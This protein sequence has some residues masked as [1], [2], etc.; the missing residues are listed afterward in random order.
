[1]L[2]E[3]FVEKYIPRVKKKNRSR[4]NGGKRW[5]T[6]SSG[7]P[8]TPFIS[9]FFGGKT[10]LFRLHDGENE[11]RHSG[12]CSEGCGQLTHVYGICCTIQSPNSARDRL[13]TLFG[14]ATRF[15]SV[16]CQENPR[17]FA[18]SLLNYSR[19]SKCD[20]RKGRRSQRYVRSAKT[21]CRSGRLPKASPNFWLYKVESVLSYSSSRSKNSEV[22]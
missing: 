22:Q 6:W 9:M 10:Y 20:R 13:Q 17:P 1:M 19:C 4:E 8:G 15:G 21:I 5:P 12:G 14:Q 3:Y 11:H 7:I 18:H 2:Q 16:Q